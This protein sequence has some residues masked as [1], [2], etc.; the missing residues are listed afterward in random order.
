MKGLPKNIILFDTEYTTWEGAMERKWS[1][2][3]EY[4]EIVQ[5][6]AI[7]V[8]TEEMRELESFSILVHPIKNPELSAYFTKLTGITQEMIEASGVT[9]AE[10]YAKFAAWSGELPLYCWGSD[11]R[12]MEEN[13]KLIGI[14]FPF[15]SLRFHNMREFFKAH[16]IPAEQYMSSTIPEY[17]GLKPERR[18]HD[19]LNDARSIL[20][21]LRALR[22]RGQGNPA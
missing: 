22:K 19:G 20:D 17:F 14:D 9:L 12:T 8:D 7:K 4:K 18:G 1:G 21:G 6:G 5:I 15:A 13:A 16:G 2:P 3:N 11:G 10:A